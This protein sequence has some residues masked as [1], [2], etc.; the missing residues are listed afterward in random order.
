MPGTKQDGFTL[1]ELLIALAIT[2][3]L[4]AVA[5]PLYTSYIDS[6]RTKVAETNLQ[7]LKLAE[8]AYFYDYQEYKDGTYDPA[9]ALNSLD[10][11]KLGW[12]P[13]QDGNKFKYVV[14]DAPC[15]SI[16]SCFTITVTG[17]DDAVTVTDTSN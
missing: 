5:V 14:T 6:S 9:H 12:K 8:I 11:D 2:A 13:D 3:V 4:T 1:V 10:I 17:F 7:S 15:G 16:K